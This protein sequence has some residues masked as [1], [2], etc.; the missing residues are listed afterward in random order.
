MLDFSSLPGTDKTL[1]D[2]FFLSIINKVS[3][4]RTD[5]NA[6]RMCLGTCRRYELKLEMDM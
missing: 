6:I 2:A 5:S 1:A 3:D 4:F